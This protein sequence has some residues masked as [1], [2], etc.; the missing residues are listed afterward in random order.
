MDEEL[1]SV[2]EDVD[3]YRDKSREELT[4]AD[5]IEGDEEGFMRGYESDADAAF[6]DNCKKVL[7]RDHL[8]KEFDGDI[9]TF[10]SEDCVDAFER[11]RE[12]TS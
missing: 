8:E 7:G 2:E 3:V 1:N 4:N 11:K 10:C 9:Y 6:C 12:T 5:E